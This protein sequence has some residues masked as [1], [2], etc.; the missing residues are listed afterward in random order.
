MAAALLEA[1]R[2]LRVANPGLGLKPLLTKLRDQQPDLETGTKEVREALTAL[3][4]ESEAKAATAATPPTDDVSSAADEGVTLSQIGPSL[5]CVGC[6]RLP[7]EMGDGREKHPVCPKCVTLKLPT[8]YFCGPNCPGNPIAW[9]MHGAYHKALNRQ[10]KQQEDGGTS[11]HWHREAA[12]RASRRAAQT[13]SKYEELVADG[14][15]Y[16]AEQDWRRAVRTY[17]EA[18]V[19]RPD[20]V[21]AYYNLGSVLAN[22][23]HTVEAAQRYLEA[24]VRA[25]VGSEEWARATAAAFEMLT[26]KECDEVTKP[27]WWNDEGLKALSARVVR[28]AP[29][30]GLGMRA[31]VLSGRCRGWVAGPRS[32][33]ELKEAASHYEQEAAL[34]NA[35]ALKVEFVRRAMALG[36][37][38]GKGYCYR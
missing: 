1:V 34:S 32:S 33:A 28:L 5:A 27:E 15:K 16:T 22:S 26:E 2:G 25:P 35:P 11:Q 4:A 21:V 38:G 17:R 18:F 10:Q 7:L 31:L 37:L 20:V 29:N 24:K 14:I 19:L 12:E 23:G 8:T 13:G 36:G 3:K 9:K 30:D 6:A